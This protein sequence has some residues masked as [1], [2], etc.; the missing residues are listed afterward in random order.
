MQNCGGLKTALCTAT[1]VLLSNTSAAASKDW[2][3]DGALLL[4]TEKGNRTNVLEPVIHFNKTLSNDDLLEIDVAVDIITGATPSGAMPS[5]QP[6]TFARPSG[7][8]TYTIAAGELPYDD[9]FQDNRI[10]IGV[11]NTTALSNDNNLIYG[12]FI[13]YEYDY[14][15]MGTQST[16]TQD[17]NNNTSTLSIGLALVHNKL[18]PEGGIPTAF[19]SA[20]AGS[21][22][23]QSDR[24]AK[25]YMTQGDLLIG[26][27]KAFSPA[28]IGQFNIGFSRSKGYHTDPFRYFSVVDAS[29]GP[30]LG[31]PVQNLFEKRPDTRNKHSIFAKLNYAISRSVLSTSYRFV[32]DSWDIQSHTVDLKYS[33]PVSRQ[34]RYLQPHIRWYHQSAAVFYRTNLLSNEELPEYVSPDYRLAEMQSITLGVKYSS[35]LRKGNKPFEIRFEYIFQDAEASPGSHIGQLAGRKIVPDTEGVLLQFN[36]IF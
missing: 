24:R 30:N 7:V 8:G 18:D 11:N 23:A 15:S 6:Q 26:L 13:S 33:F 28:L 36:Y 5:S 27:T 21:R 2:E 9:T 14:M 17:F 25:E 3:V 10:E 35:Y 29:P 1:S 22:E 4:Y 20:A 16:L 32:S 31:E 34:E 19:S 12:G